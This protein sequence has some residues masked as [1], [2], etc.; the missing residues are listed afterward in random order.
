VCYRIHNFNTDK[1]LR[2]RL[3]KEAANMS[4]S[5]S[6]FR[7]LTTTTEYGCDRNLNGMDLLEGIAGWAISPLPQRPTPRRRLA[8]T[9]VDTDRSTFV[10]C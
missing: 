2:N 4:A 5:S 6:L 9:F 3:K 8:D 7:A 1:E 10:D